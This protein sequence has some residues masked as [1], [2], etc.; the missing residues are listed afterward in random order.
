MLAQGR[1]ACVLREAPERLERR[2]GLL[3]ED[4][5]RPGAGGREREP[6]LGQAPPRLDAQG[7]QLLD[8][9]RDPG[10]DAGVQLEHRREELRLEARSV[11][12]ALRHRSRLEHL[13]VEDEELLLEPDR[14]RRRLAEAVRHH[15]R[16]A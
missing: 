3:T 8:R 5:G 9:L 14:E 13:G 2:D 11:E 6:V 4:G 15:P 16:K 7:R 12:H 1:G 10:A